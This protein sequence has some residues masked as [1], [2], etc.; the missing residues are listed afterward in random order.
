MYSAAVTLSIVYSQEV[1]DAEEKVGG[2]GIT[3][4]GIQNNVEKNL[5]I[6]GVQKGAELQKVYVLR[7]F[8]PLPGQWTRVL[9]ETNLPMHEH[10]HMS[11][12]SHLLKETI[13]LLMGPST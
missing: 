6:V 13:H 1:C 5:S 4:S 7:F 2:M 3:P 10:P 8:R 9:G 11:L 12:V